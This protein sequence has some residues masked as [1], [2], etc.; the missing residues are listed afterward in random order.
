MKTIVIEGQRLLRAKKAGMDLVLLNFLKEL[1]KYQDQF[2]FLV[3]VKEGQGLEALQ[4][5]LNME[6]VPVSGKSY[7]DWEQ[8]HLP[9]AIKKINPDLVHYT[10]NT[11]PFKTAQC[12]E[13][14]T[15]HDIIFLERNVRQAF[16]GS[17]YQIM[18]NIYR[19]LVVPQVVSRMS[20]I[21]TV[22][23]FEKQ[24]I[25][26][27][28]S[29]KSL[30]VSTIYNGV[31]FGEP[32]ALDEGTV[33]ENAHF[34]F[35]IANTEPRKNT[36]NVIKAYAWY[37][38]QAS[39]KHALKMCGINQ[40][41]LRSLLKKLK[42]EYLEQHIK[43]TGY[44]SDDQLMR[45]YQNAKALLFP[46]LREGFGLPPLEAMSLGTP[47]IVSNNSSI[48][49]VCGDAGLY[50]DP[51]DYS[52][53]GQKMMRIESDTE[54]QTELQQLGKLQSSKFSWA[55]SAAQLMNVYQKNI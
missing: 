8:I 40:G 48:P 25:E 18:G 10:S 13:I 21:I 24:N 16:K 26:N 17:P 29:N 11:A 4:I 49:E 35:H 50:V 36:A 42:L 7:P 27:F 3:L 41:Q 14:L 52:D 2:R 28:F 6:I 34:F 46:S 39:K 43:L 45:T 54:L 23:N 15:L 53:I 51:I 55:Q 30:N 5:S 12:P 1:S 9:K 22:S 31:G 37:L 19:K 32:K 38:L 44:L 33:N 47:V 20:E